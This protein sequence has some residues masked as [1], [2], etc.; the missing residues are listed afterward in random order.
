MYGYSL[1]KCVVYGGLEGLSLL[2]KKA[3]ASPPTMPA[4]RV[5]IPTPLEKKQIVWKKI[6]K[7]PKM[8]LGK[9]I[10]DWNKK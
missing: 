8:T 2:F 1:T 3:R 6:M 9:E 5:G 7:P 10:M 4:G